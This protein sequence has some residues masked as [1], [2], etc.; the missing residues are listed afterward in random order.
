MASFSPSY[1]PQQAIVRPYQMH[2]VRSN[3]YPNPLAVMEQTS[4]ADH[5]VQP[6]QTTNQ[7]LAGTTGLSRLSQCRCQLLIALGRSTTAFDSKR[8][9]AMMYVWNWFGPRSTFLMLRCLH[10]RLSVLVA[11]FH[12][13]PLYL[14]SYHCNILQPVMVATLRFDPSEQNDYRNAFLCYHPQYRAKSQPNVF[15]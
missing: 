9:L 10:S 1:H 6:I 14:D 7:P 4:P 8:A 3:T 15:P 12:Q 5:H 2:I 11:N 13:I